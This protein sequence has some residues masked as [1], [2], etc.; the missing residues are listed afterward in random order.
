MIL[1]DIN[2]P[3]PD[4]LEA[5]DALRRHPLICRTEVGACSSSDDPRDRARAIEPGADFC[6][7]KPVDP[8]GVRA[9]AERPVEPLRASIGHC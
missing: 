5:L 1:L 6:L 9:L 8:E 7:E 2:L 4:G 3:G